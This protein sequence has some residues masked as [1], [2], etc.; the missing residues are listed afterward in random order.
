MKT[1]YVTRVATVAQY[2]VATVEAT[3]ELEARRIADN[4]ENDDLEWESNPF[5]DNILDSRIL[6]VEEQ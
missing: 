3:D 6:S 5:K 4:D 2:E 1:F